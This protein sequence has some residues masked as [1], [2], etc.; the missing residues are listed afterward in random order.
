MSFDSAPLQSRRHRVKKTG[1][2]SSCEKEPCS[3]ALL[4]KTARAVPTRRTPSALQP[5]GDD[6]Q[7]EPSLSVHFC[8]LPSSLQKWLPPLSL[9][10][11]GKG[12]C[13]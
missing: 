3:S 7:A 8:Q 10:K 12:I 5:S 9:L 6:L 11:V 2:A 1:S 4:R 13:D